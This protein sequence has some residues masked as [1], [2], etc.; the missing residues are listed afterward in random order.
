LSYHQSNN[1]KL[2]SSK[3]IKDILD[4]LKMNE[5]LDN[6]PKTYENYRKNIMKQEEMQ[7]K[8]ENYSNSIL[9]KE[10]E[11]LQNQN[12]NR[13]LALINKYNNELVKLNM[14]SRT[15]DNKVSIKFDI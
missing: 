5:I 15:L 1:K 8:L 4:S 14:K 10:Q 3:Q 6:N 12:A 13:N 2:N 11:L 7:K 9:K